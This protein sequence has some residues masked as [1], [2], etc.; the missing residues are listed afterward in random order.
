[1]KA[2]SR[3]KQDRFV[4]GATLSP[5]G[6]SDTTSSRMIFQNQQHMIITP[7]TQIK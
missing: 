5:A 7:K 6:G 1:M 2:S 3:I 4:Q